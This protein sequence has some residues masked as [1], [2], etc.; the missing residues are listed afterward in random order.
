MGDSG[1]ADLRDSLGLHS[2]RHV[3][4][5][6]VVAAG[7]D[8]LGHLGLGAAATSAIG[9]EWRE[10]AQ[11][12][13]AAAVGVAPDVVGRLASALGLHEDLDMAARPPQ[14]MSQLARRSKGVIPEGVVRG[15]RAVQMLAAKAGSKDKAGELQKSFDALADAW[16]TIVLRRGDMVHRPM[17]MPSGWTQARMA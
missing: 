2:S 7:R 5:G 3:G 9:D 16:D 12:A 1:A 13:A 10:A 11:G 17:P 8:L 14:N 4:H 6:D 15:S